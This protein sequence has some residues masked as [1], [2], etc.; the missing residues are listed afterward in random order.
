M[1]YTALTHQFRSRTAKAQRPQR[2]RGGNSQIETNAAF[3]TARAKFW[4]ICKELINPE[5]TQKNLTICLTIHQQVPF[6]VQATDCLFDAGLGSRGT[7]GLS[8]YRYDKDGNRIDNITDWGLAQFQTHYKDSTITKL[9][10]FHYTYS[11]FV[12]VETMEIIQQ[13]EL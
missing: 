5:V 4:G 3:Q 9:D 11:V 2:K 7:Q 12:S 13:I 10:I 6:V 1:R 8:L